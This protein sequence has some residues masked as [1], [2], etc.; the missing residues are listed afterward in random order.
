MT[1]AEYLERY[2]RAISPNEGSPESQTANAVWARELR[3]AYLLMR[4]IEERESKE[5]ANQEAIREMRRELAKREQLRRV[6]AEIREIEE[7]E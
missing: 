6:D 3:Q 4:N 1:S 5:V 2:H 7:E